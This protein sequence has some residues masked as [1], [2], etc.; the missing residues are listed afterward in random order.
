[1]PSMCARGRGGIRQSRARLA[2]WAL[3]LSAAMLAV[4]LSPA[5][6]A[7]QWAQGTPK[8]DE[9][10][11]ANLATLEE[12]VLSGEYVVEQL[13]PSKFMIDADTYAC[14]ARRTVQPLP[15]QRRADSPSPLLLGYRLL[16]AQVR[17]L[18]PS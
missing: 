1:M 16:L 3:A 10:F 18:L 13:F 6:A 8:F 4:L 7:A 15:C 5:P 14:V 17:A 11:A 9:I 2:P 12:Q